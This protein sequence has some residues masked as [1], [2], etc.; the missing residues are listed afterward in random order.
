MLGDGS[1]FFDGQLGTPEPYA[2]APDALSATFP[3]PLTGAS[4]YVEKNFDTWGGLQ[5]PTIASPPTLAAS[6][7]GYPA[8]DPALRYILDFFYAFIVTDKMATAA[9]A[10]A[11][12]A[13]P[14]ILNARST[15]AHNPSEMVF[16]TSFIPAL[17]LWRES[18]KEE[19]AAEDWLRETTLVKGLWV[20]P[21]AL[22][23][24]Q[25]Q[26]TTFAHALVKAINVGLERGR[27]PGYVVPGDTDPQAQAYG[28]NMY[29]F[30]GFESFSLAS[31]AKTTVT[32]ETVNSPGAP[33]SMRYP[34]VE[35]IFTMEENLVYGLD[36]YA[37]N[38][39][40]G[41]VYATLLGPNGLPIISG[42][43]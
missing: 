43:F 17:F 32:V 6:P 38:S 13:A 5:I 37:P 9:W 27:T 22:P 35:L 7:N 40:S 20:F 42:P 39:P 36:R 1:Q 14:P 19:W 41:G 2:P 23:E 11:Y 25:R 24:N 29:T 3:D 12:P 30:A 16:S 34:A 28:S 21:L 26:R 8:G 10:Q 33:P 31:W 4:V 18:G 15:F